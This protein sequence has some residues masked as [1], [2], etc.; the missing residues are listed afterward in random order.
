MKRETV[1]VV[2]DRADRDWTVTNYFAI[3]R[4]GRLVVQWFESQPQDWQTV[5]KVVL[6]LRPKHILDESNLTQPWQM[7]D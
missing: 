4:E 1:L 3:E 5:G 7:D 2:I 6:I